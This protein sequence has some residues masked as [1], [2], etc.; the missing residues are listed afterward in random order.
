MSALSPL[1]GRAPDL[2]EPI[3]GFRQWRLRGHTLSSLFTDMPWRR[4]EL[5]ARC[6]VGGHDPRKAPSKRTD[7]VEV[8]E[9]L[10]VPGVAYR[11]LKSVG[12]QHGSP[13][14]RSLRPARN[15]APARSQPPIGA[16]PRA[17]SCA[18]LAIHR[19]PPP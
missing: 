9:R 12:T 8:A 17:V 3:M 5:R 7:L 19:Q 6:T 14:R 15:W 18:L 11:E 2:V 10:G 13:L 1:H 16:V 4:N